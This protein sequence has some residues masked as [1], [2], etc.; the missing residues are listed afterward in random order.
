MGRSC[1]G[2]CIRFFVAAVLVLAGIFL[3]LTWVG[4]RLL[5]KY[6]GWLVVA[7]TEERADA[8][9]ILGGG[10]GE[11]LHAGVQLYKAGRAGYLL[12]TGPDVPLLK[13]YSTED[14]LTQGE[15]KRRIAVRRGVPDDSI[16][17]ALG[18]TSTWQEALRARSESESHHW[19]SIVVVTDPFHT[20]RTKATFERVFRGSPIRIGI[21][22]LPEGRSAQKVER[23]WTRESDYMA[24]VTESMK[25]VFYVYSYGIRP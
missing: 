6:A 14:S 21:Y 4:P 9:I 12:I 2:G 11:R 25:L 20:R 18:P 17:L 24:V 15:A 1:L 5:E 7:S 23:W 10:D 3:V 13:V 16:L 19:N 8:A 22:H